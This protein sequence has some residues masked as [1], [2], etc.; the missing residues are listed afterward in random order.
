MCQNFGG[1]I[2]IF[3]ESF[4]FGAVQ[5]KCENLVDLE[6]SCHAANVYVLLLAHISF[7]TADNEPS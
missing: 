7:G 1:A 5:Q 6:T 2:V 4:E 3:R